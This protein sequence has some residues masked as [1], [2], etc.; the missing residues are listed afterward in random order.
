M[1]ASLALHP[2][3]LIY[4]GS[5]GGGGRGLGREGGEDGDVRG[6]GA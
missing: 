3:E 2:V 5:H 1:P 4:L 6:A